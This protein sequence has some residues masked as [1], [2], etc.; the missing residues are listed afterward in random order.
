VPLAHAEFVARAV[1]NAELFTLEDCGHF[2][3][4][5]PGARQAA[6][7]VR[8]FLIRHAP[9]TATQAGSSAPG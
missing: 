3:W 5:G 4:V 1:P 6:E 9:Q 2:V 8:A 7:K